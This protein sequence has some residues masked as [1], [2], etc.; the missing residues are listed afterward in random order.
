MV[1]IMMIRMVMVPLHDDDNHD[2]DYHDDCDDEHEDH[3]EYDA[4]GDVVIARVTVIALMNMM[5]VM[6]R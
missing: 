1:I 3:D 2:D 6:T 4:D 5:M